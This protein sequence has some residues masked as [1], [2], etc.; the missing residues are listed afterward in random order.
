L[1][2]MMIRHLLLLVLASLIL[3]SC[4]NDT[5]PAGG[6]PELPVTVAKPLIRNV[7]EWDEYTGRFEAVDY[8]EVRSR[9]SG[10][11]VRVAF[12]E[13]EVVRKGDLLY[14]IDARPFEVALDQAKAQLDDSLARADFARRDF[15]RAK[16]L[17][18]TQDVPG[19]VFDQRQQDLSTAEAA[20]ARARAAVRDA[21]LNLSYTQIRAPVGG[22]TSATSI[23]EGNLV[24][25]GSSGA[26]LTT[27]ASL[28][29]IH[30]VFDAD[31]AA[32]LKYVGLAA[33]GARPSSRDVANPVQL[34]LLNETDFRHT[35]RMDFVDNQINRDTG[36]MRGR[37]IFDNPGNVFIPGMFGKM[38]L[39]GS[40][41]YDAMLIPDE[42]VGTD[43]TSK[44]VYVVGPNNSIGP[45]PVV[46]GPMIDGLRVVRSGI[47]P[48]DRLVIN[49]LMR[50]RP[51]LKVK[52]VDGTIELPAVAAAA[53]P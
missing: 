2:N 19:R 42:A 16:E 52:P 31:E 37:A 20:V 4:G 11:L 36:T 26:P 15:N 32:Y 9:V 10:Y 50:L 18:V 46:L 43:Q 51:D 41:R 6:P 12:R 28:N 3:A 35:G 48:S 38:R 23:T 30:F 14:A 39:L 47:A 8:V 25:A 40:G 5:A 24:S 7:Q 33:Q 34:Q 13:G 49:G 53:K 44:I 17:R 29:P 45:R 1:L 27:V 22:R 21:Q